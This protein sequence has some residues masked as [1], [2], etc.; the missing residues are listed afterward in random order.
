M[1]MLRVCGSPVIA[2]WRHERFVVI[3]RVTRTRVYLIDPSSGRWSLTHHAFLQYFKGMVLMLEPGAAFERCPRRSAVV[4]W[5]RLFDDG[6]GRSDILS[7]FGLLLACSLVLQTSSLLFP[8]LAYIVIDWIIPNRLWHPL[9]W[10]MAGAVFAALSH[11]ALRQ[12]RALMLLRFQAVVEWWLTMKV[13]AK[14]LMLPGLR[15]ETRPVEELLRR[16]AAVRVVRD[17]IA[18]RGV[19]VVLDGVFACVPLFVLSLWSF[20]FALLAMAV[21]LVE[22]V[23]HALSAPVMRDV[24]YRQAAVRARV[25]DGLVGLLRGLTSIKL[26]GVEAVALGVWSEGFREQLDL[27]AWR[28]E[29]RSAVDSLRAGLR[30]LVS[31]MFL[32]AGA[33]EVLEGRISIAEMIALNA[34]VAAFLIPIGGLFGVLSQWPAMC[35]RFER[36]RDLLE[37]EADVVG[38]RR[39]P[40]GFV[41]FDLELDRVRFQ[42]HSGGPW[43]VDEVSVAIRGKRLVAIV[44]RVGSGK[45]ALARLL[46]GM[47][48][49]ES[50]QI[51][52]AGVPLADVDRGDLRRRCGV[53]LQ[54]SV[55]FNGSIRDNIIFHRPDV[56]EDDLV[57]TSAMVEL[58]ESVLALPMGYD[59]PVFEAGGGLSGG[60]RQRVLLARALV[61][62]PALVVLD[63]AMGHLDVASERRVLERLRHTRCLTVVVAQR[64]AAV[65][66][67]DL[68]LVLRDG[69]LVESGTHDRLVAAAGLY[70]RLAAEQGLVDDG[71]GVQSVGVRE[72]GMRHGTDG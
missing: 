36:L 23:M 31:M 43:V 9:S 47:H 34:L 1:E 7:T 66:D 53:V 32:A 29:A 4:W 28:R 51:S 48:Q 17:V 70:A 15:G 65:R 35:V 61:R 19:G 38:A 49:P 44:G 16:V 33:W 59:T 45:S 25:R 57:Q 14:V 5:W 72:G 24:V 67:A 18:E 71:G 63:E 41:G 55:L 46:I 39:L 26:A 56:T 2:H 22:L 30:V 10:L 12:A 6:V 40:D 64:L 62:R 42:Y 58:H 3:V 11:A 37:G 69:R 50:G 8:W 54:N 60:Q 27:D 52:L 20:R 13:V 68:I 21:A